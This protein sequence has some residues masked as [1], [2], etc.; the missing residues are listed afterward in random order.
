MNST[1]NLIYNLNKEDTYSMALM[2]LY[3]SSDN[4]DF[5]VLSELVFILDKS[6]FLNFI[7][8]FE[9]QTLKIPNIEQISESLKLLLLY[10]YYKINNMSFHEALQKAGFNLTDS[11]SIR[12]KLNKFCSK[13]NKYNF[14][15]N[16][17]FN[18][19]GLK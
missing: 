12:S 10:Q 8:Y 3:L 13:I 19:K 17:L 7:K 18:N 4:P 14:G 2:L 9:G 5:S 1:D 11:A 6:N 15:K 16:Q